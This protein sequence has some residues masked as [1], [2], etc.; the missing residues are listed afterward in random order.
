MATKPQLMKVLVDI[1]TRDPYTYE[2]DLPV[3][4]GDKVEFPTADWMIPHVG[5][6]SVGVVVQL[7]SDYPGPCVKIVRILK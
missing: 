1:G 3:K 6:L 7:G 5:E 4:V 2:T